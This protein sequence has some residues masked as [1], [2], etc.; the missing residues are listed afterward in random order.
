MEV[1]LKAGPGERIP[2]G[3]SGELVKWLAKTV[4][5]SDLPP[6]KRPKDAIADFTVT[7]V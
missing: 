7:E 3:L 6:A 2:P 5:R 4:G 1:T